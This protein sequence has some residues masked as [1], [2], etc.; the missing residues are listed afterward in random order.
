ME[1]FYFFFY[2]PLLI[3]VLHILTD[4]ILHKLRNL[5]PTPFPAIPFLGHL[6]LLQEPAHVY[7]SKLAKK[8][9]PV[10]SLKLGRVHVVVV[11]SPLAAGD[12]FVK[13]DINF[14]NRP[15]FLY[16]KYFGND[17]TSLVWSPYGQR[18]R[19][20]RRISTIEI[21]S[22]NKIQS[23]SAIRADEVHSLI[24][25]LFRVTVE[26]PG[27]LAD[28]RTACFDLTFNVMTR[29]IAGK[30]YYGENVENSKEAKAFHEILNGITE[31]TPKASMLDFLPFMRWFGANGVEN[32]MKIVQERRDTFMQDLID[33]HRKIDYDSGIKNKT[34]MKELLQAGSDTTASTMEWAMAHLIDNPN[35]LQKAQAEIDDVVGQER[36]IAE[37]DLPRLPYIRCI[38]NETLRLHP[39]SPLLVPHETSEAC[40]V[41]GFKIPAKT[42]IF[43]NAWDIH[44][45]PKYWDDPEKFMPERFEGLELGGGNGGKAEELKFIPFGS[46]RRGCPGSNLAMHVLG[47][48][49]G[50]LIQCF[51]WEIENGKFMDLSEGIGAPTYKAQ[52]LEAKCYPRSNML[53]LLSHL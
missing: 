14:A 2:L 7:L 22:S 1:A 25:K 46:G 53:K 43:V 5:P 37:N 3:L 4:Q 45:N 51:N 12:C 6:Y 35:L 44:R 38:I 20:L 40:I 42:V 33:E 15:R 23:L 9:G 18:W 29:M 11:S 41:E 48:A 47:L 19:N 31:L 30:R 32:Q 28:M 50:S 26:D 10:F 49:L 34:M 8:Y 16:G 21:F 24:R 17:Y 52:P 39:A 13:N 27:R 36:L